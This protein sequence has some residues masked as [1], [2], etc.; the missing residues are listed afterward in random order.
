MENNKELESKNGF[1]KTVYVLNKELIDNCATIAEILLPSV[2]IVSSLV[3]TLDYLYSGEKNEYTVFSMVISGMF[4]AFIISFVTYSLLEILL[5]WVEKIKRIQRLPITK[6]EFI[7][8]GCMTQ[9]DAVAFLETYSHWER[10]SLIFRKIRKCEF[11]NKELPENIRLQ[12]I[13][14][15]EELAGNLN[16]KNSQWLRP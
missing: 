7:K 2:V 14:T 9:E 3:D 11:Y 13:H 15:I 1:I 12:L 8:N 4:L 10:R 16:Y 5:D 6:E